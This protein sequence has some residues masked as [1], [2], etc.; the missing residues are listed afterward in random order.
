MVLLFG[1][2]LSLVV[3]AG[4]LEFGYSPVLARGEKPMFSVTPPRD[5]NTLWVRV[6]A[7]EGRWE[8]D[9]NGARGGEELRFYWDR[10]ETVSEA[11][12]TVKVV[13]TDGYVEAVQVPVSYSYGG[14]L[15]VD[16]G[17]ASADLRAHT[18][19]VQVSHRV[20]RAD[21][22]AYGAHKSVLDE[23]TVRIDG[24]PGEIDVPWVG[25][26]AEVVLLDVT[27]HGANAWAGFTYSPW[28]LDI[29]HDEVVFDTGSWEITAEQEP[30]LHRLKQDLDEVVE[31]YGAVVPVKLYIAGC[32]DTVGSSLAN[33]SL[34]QHRAHAIGKWLQAHGFEQPVFVHGFGE[35]WLATPTADGVDNAANRRALYMVAANP[36]P[37]S[38]GVPPAR[39]ASL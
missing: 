12:V 29:P 16:L 5:V 8:F 17:R 25:D 15:M 4:E 27:L 23:R 14:Q 35:S 21:L 6:E 3:S 19:T 33:A 38:A 30:K 1:L 39:W 34:S 18:L 7:G 31:K 26:P 13:F 9:R 20:E 2:L 32:T 11:L 10:D 24:G 28:F 22:I 37:A 36:P